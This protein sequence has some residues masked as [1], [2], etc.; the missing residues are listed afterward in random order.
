MECVV[1][2]LAGRGIR[3]VNG[4]VEARTWLNQVGSR[5]P[6]SGLGVVLLKIVCKGF[7]Y[8]FCFSHALET[9]V[10]ERV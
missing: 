6:V 10:E 2:L 5:A 3:A 4:V 7:D 8:N 1:D 9:R